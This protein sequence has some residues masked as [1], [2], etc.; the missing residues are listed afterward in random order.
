MTIYRLKWVVSSRWQNLRT[1]KLQLVEWSTRNDT[2][3]GGK[4]GSFD[5]LAWKW[6]S[7]HPCLPA[8]TEVCELAERSNESVWKFGH[9]WEEAWVLCPKIQTHLSGGVRRCERPQTMQQQHS[10]EYLLFVR[11]QPTIWDTVYHLASSTILQLSS[12]GPS[13]QA[14]VCFD[15]HFADWRASSSFTQHTIAQSITSTTART[16]KRKNHENL[17]DNTFTG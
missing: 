11:M 6:V 5:S 9:I 1:L 15:N 17:Q 3:R 4:R 7:S 14:T 8:S 12:G 2:P 16:I 10:Y 13:T